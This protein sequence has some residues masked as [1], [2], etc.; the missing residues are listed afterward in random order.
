MVPL[1]SHPLFP[2]AVSDM[3]TDLTIAVLPSTSRL[4]L[5]IRSRT[6][7]QCQGAAKSLSSSEPDVQ[8]PSNTREE[9]T[10]TIVTRKIATWRHIVSSMDLHMSL[11]F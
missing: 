5:R 2:A 8:R 6:Q 4:S 1:S 3:V 9:H 10:Q 11:L 7:N